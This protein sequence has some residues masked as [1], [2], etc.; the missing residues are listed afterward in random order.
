[1][2]NLSGVSFGLLQECCSGREVA[3]GRGRELFFYYKVMQYT[4]KFFLS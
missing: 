2:K 4:R 3:A 1:M